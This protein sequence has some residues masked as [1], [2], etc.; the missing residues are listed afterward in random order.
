MKALRKGIIISMI[1]IMMLVS[2]GCYGHFPLTKAIYR[3]NG[4]I[5]GEV[6]VDSSKRNIVRS[7][8]MWVFIIFQVYSIGALVDVIVLNVMEFW[9][10]NVVQIGSADRDGIHYAFVPSADGREATLTL[11]R[12]GKVLNTT[13]FVRISDK[14]MEVRNADGR[15]TG[16]LLRG[17]NGIDWQQAAQPAA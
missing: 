8:V 10:G 16:K 12:D 17:A 6:N 5:G 3:T 7:L 14:V 9:T 1:A 11:S 2:T 15:V 13:H 4:N